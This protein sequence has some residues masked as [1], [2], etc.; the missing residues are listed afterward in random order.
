MGNLSGNEKEKLSNLE[1]KLHERIVGQ[2]E[3]VSALS[4]AMRRAVLNVSAR[5]KPI[6]TFL[7]LGPT[8]VGK[9]ETAKALAQIYFGNENRLV[10]FDMSEYQGEIGL[11]RLLDQLP[12]ALVNN[13]FAVVLFD[14]IEKAPPLISNL[15]LT[16]LDEGYITDTAN[17]K[18][19]AK[20]NIIIGTSNAGSLYIKN[21]GSEGLIDYIQNKKI[22]SPEFIN[23]FDGVIVFKPLDDAQIKEV[24]KKLLAGVA[25][26]LEDKK[27]TLEFSQDLVNRI[28]KEGYQ[29]EFGARSIRRYLQDTIEDEISQKLLAGDFPP[30]STL[31]I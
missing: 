5:N 12:K 2:N 26:R 24:A 7:F 22:F 4:R 3:A 17:H 1:E 27:I 20:Q 30:G 11:E 16:L 29:P 15:F 6:G 8:G 25:K 23:R 28:I 13:P 10:R 21:H 18:V 9:T 19:S 14:E 31:K